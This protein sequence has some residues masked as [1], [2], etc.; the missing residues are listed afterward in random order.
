MPPDVAGGLVAVLGVVSV[1]TLILIGMRM[2]FL[3]KMQAR[4]EP[5]ELE[6]IHDTLDALHDE[7][8]ALREDVAELQE[9]LDFHERLLT[10]PREERVDTPV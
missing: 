3:H 10:Q 8:R 7:N 9:R 2:R 5:G 1:G 4:E 6:R